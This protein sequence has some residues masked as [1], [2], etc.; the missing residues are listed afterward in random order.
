MRI[1]P[2]PILAS[3]A[4]LA[5][6]HLF[7][8]LRR[9][10]DPDEF[11]ALVNA[12]DAARGLTPYID[13]WDNHGP[14]NIWLLQPI[15]AFWHGQ[16]SIVHG[17]HSLIYWLRGLMWLNTLAVAAATYYLA[18]RLYP[19]THIP[20][21]AL[22]TLLTAPLFIS[23]T[24]EIR[25][26]N[27]S[28][29]L[30][31]LTLIFLT[32]AFQ[33]NRR[34]HY[35]LAGLTLGL[36]AGFTLKVIILAAALALFAA[37]WHI[38]NRQ[39]PHITSW[40]L[41]ILAAAAPVAL[42]SATLYLQGNLAAFIDCYFG[43]NVNRPFAGFT[44]S[45]FLNIYKKSP[46]WTI[47]VTIA[48]F[49]S[50]WR[51]IRRRADAPEAGLTLIALFLLAQFLLLMPTKNSQSLLPLFPPLAIITG[52][53][54]AQWITALRSRPWFTSRT[55]TIAAAI[56]TLLLL[57]DINDYANLR[58]K[59]LPKQVRFADKVL[60]LT[61]NEPVIF[62]PVGVVFLKPK[63]GPFHVLVTFIREMHQ[64][65]TIDLHITESLNISDSLNPTKS[66]EP[67]VI[68]P[69]NTI[70]FHQRA[71][72]LRLTDLNT[73]RQNF[74]PVLDGPDSVLLQRHPTTPKPQSRRWKT[75]EFEDAK[76]PTQQT[77]T[78]PTWYQNFITRY[79]RE[80]VKRIKN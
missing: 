30:F 11:Q 73:I 62:D 66:I 67:T 13:F 10:A 44:S 57:R 61:H 79:E 34:L 56:L 48:L 23:K 75:W 65:G 63:P 3:V 78:P 77:P 1:F 25:G 26:D 40:L 51:I 9:L 80:K 6:L 58:N 31:T 4:L 17:G 69:I 16:N 29:L 21:I 19:R 39:R 45:E 64:A 22:L 70:A 74:T 52:I 35:A 38:I 60:S 54:F 24:I 15:L 18:R 27:P 37:A 42:I 20:A 72:D 47:P 33:T 32:L 50:A 2:I 49:T 68:P 8:G 5:A 41:F 71:G 43:G 53:I 59:E 14:L 36:I 55:A 28:N 12:F 76:A 46:V 7:H